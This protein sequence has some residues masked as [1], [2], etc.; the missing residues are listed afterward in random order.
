MMTFPRV[1]CFRKSRIN[2]NGGNHDSYKCLVTQKL[3]N[4]NVVYHK[5]KNPFR[6][7]ICMNICLVP[8]RLAPGPSR[9]LIS[10]T[11]LR[12]TA[13]SSLDNN[14]ARMRSSQQRNAELQGIIF[15]FFHKLLLTARNRRSSLPDRLCYPDNFNHSHQIT[16]S[17]KMLTI[18]TRRNGIGNFIF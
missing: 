16:Q 2:E 17:E 10:V 14:R 1:F 11:Y 15:L 13:R 4:W 8:V 3:K 9:Q 7:K 6:A 5:T 18:A 12:G